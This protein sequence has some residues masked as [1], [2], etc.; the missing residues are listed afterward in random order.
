M[1]K[2]NTEIIII[3]NEQHIKITFFLLPSEKKRGKVNSLF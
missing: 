2:N 3:I 1:N